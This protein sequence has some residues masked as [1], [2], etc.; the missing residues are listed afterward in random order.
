MEDEDV[1]KNTA[2]EKKIVNWIPDK[3]VKKCEKCDSKF[4]LTN[5]RVKSKSKKKNF[6]QYTKK[7][8]I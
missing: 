1:E 8:V 2:V 6:I 5:R 4:T 7:K 3:E